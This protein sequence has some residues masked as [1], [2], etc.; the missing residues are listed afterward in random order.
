MITQGACA[1]VVPGWEQGYVV[2]CS[3]EEIHH[4]NQKQPLSFLCDRDNRDRWVSLWVRHRDHFR[5]VT[6]YPGGLPPQPPH[7]GNGCLLHPGGGHPGST[8]VW[9]G[10]RTHRP[11][12]DRHSSGG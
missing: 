9:V 5:R 4:A 7:A 3:E 10:H 1:F 11:P 8:D 2:A 12:L 6:V